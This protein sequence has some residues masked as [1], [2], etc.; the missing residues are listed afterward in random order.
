M[1]DL[2]ICLQEEERVVA[3]VVGVHRVGDTAA[4]VAWPFHDIAITNIVWF[5][6]HNRG[7]GEGGVVYCAMDVQ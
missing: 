3:C 5:M 1:C 6:A 4:V 7:V 2:V